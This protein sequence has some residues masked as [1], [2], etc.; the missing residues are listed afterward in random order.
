ME[1]ADTF[2]LGAA[3]LLAPHMT[4]KEARRTALLFCLL[5]VFQIVLELVKK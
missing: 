3:I 5:A 2:F 4:G 1:M